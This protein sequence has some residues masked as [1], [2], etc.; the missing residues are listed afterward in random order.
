MSNTVQQ[1]NPPTSA[2]DD[3]DLTFDVDYPQQLSRWKTA[4]RLVLASPILALVAILVGPYRFVG[5]TDH[6]G[7][8][9]GRLQSPMSLMLAAC[10]FSRPC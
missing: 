9:P 7:L 10:S 1:T 8:T 6:G 2:R 3:L 5:L 4:F